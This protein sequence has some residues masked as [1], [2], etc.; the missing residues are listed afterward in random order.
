MSELTI[1]ELKEKIAMVDKDIER[2]RS[3]GADLKHIS[4]LTEYKSYLEE[5]LKLLQHEQRQ[6]R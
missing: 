1:P 2:L 6:H 5:D 4:A 3:T